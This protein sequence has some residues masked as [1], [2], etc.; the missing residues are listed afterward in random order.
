MP[1]EPEGVGHLLADQ[2]VDDHLS[3]VQHL[4][5]PGHCVLRISLP[6]Y[7]VPRMRIARHFDPLRVDRDVREAHH[8]PQIRSAESKIDRLL[9]PSDDADALATGAITQMRPARYNKPGRRCRPSSRR[10]C[11]APVPWFRSAK[12]LRSTMLPAASRL[13]A[14]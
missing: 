11:P 4:V 5:A 8:S 14:W 12:I 7:F 3:A 1:A 13:L 9:G 6:A 10:V 2:V